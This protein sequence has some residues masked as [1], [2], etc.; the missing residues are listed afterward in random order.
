MLQQTTVAAVGPYFERFITRF[1]TVTTLADADEQEVLRHWAGLGYYSRARNLHRA[2][3]ILASQHEGILPPSAEVWKELPGVGPYIL[4]AVLSQAFDLPMPIVE[5]NTKR[6]FARLFAQSG[7][8]ASKEMQTW[9]WSTAEN[10]LPSERIGDFNQALMEVG[11]TVCTPKKPNCSECPF[12]NT[13]R[14][15]EEGNP[16]K[17]PSPPKKPTI[18]EV[19]EVALVATFE[20]KHLLFLRPSEG[21]WA[22]MW[23]FPHREVTTNHETTLEQIRTDYALE[24]ETFTE[25]LVVKYAVTRYRYTMHVYQLHCT[26]DT[27][28]PFVHKQGVWIA[29]EDLGKLPVGSAQT[30]IIK[31][32]SKDQGTLFS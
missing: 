7:D 18:T 16:E 8:L 13:C 27:F 14:A 21:R 6:L 20:G 15:Y 3:K 32:L 22:N 4:G 24:G 9:L 5:A 23:E 28:T 11:A 17:Y 1:P 26:S 30:K 10:I 31:Y 25:L 2:A 12:Q 19:E 29:R